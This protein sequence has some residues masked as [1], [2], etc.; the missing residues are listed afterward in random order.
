MFSRTKVS[1]GKQMYF[2]TAA[3]RYYLGKK[4]MAYDV[5]KEVVY[6]TPDRWLQ[7]EDVAYEMHMRSGFANHQ[8]HHNAM[9]LWGMSAVPDDFDKKFEFLST[10]ETMLRFIVGRGMMTMLGNPLQRSR[11]PDS[12]HAAPFPAL[13]STYPLQ[14]YSDATRDLS[15]GTITHLGMV[16]GLL[17]SGGDANFTIG[18]EWTDVKPTLQRYMDT[19]TSTI[20]G[21]EKKFAAKDCPNSESIHLFNQLLWTESSCQVSESGQC[22]QLYVTGNLTFL[23]QVSEV[24][25]GFEKEEWL[26]PGWPHHLWSL[27][28]LRN[29]LRFLGIR[30]FTMPI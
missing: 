9:R 19:L 24:L 6:L 28:F 25:L 22:V 12:G 2:L 17:A 15:A 21:Q 23:L 20:N 29:R 14:L 13:P 5:Q 16:L 30:G 4:V 26:F 11:K 1:H 10:I 7:A 18:F 3:A 8:M 27:Q